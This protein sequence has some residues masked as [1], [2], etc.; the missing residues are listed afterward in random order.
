MST[1]EGISRRTLFK[2][3]GGGIVIFIGLEPLIVRAQDARRLYPEDFNAYLIVGDNGRVTVFSGKI[4]MGQGVLTSQAQMVAE[5]LDVELAAIDMVLGDTD[6]CPWDMGT[7]GSLT[8]RMFGP[9]LRAAA[10]KARLALM[11]L[12]AQKLGVPAK[13]LFVKDGVVS[14]IAEPS[15]RLS[16]G[17]LSKGARIAQVVDQNA[18]LRS[19]SK[20]RVMGS[21]PMRLDAL[22][23]V[24][25]AAKYAADIRIPGMVYAR[26]LRPPMHGAQLLKLD[27]SDA[28]KLAG[29]TLIKRGDLIA[30]L[31]M[32]PEA[33]GA[34]LAKIKADWRL[35]E[36]TVDQDSIFE[37]I[38]KHAVDQ[39]TIANKGDLVAAR[40]AATRLFE[41]TYQKGYVAHAAI[42][43]HAA[44]AEIKG[45]KATIWAS[46]QTPF[47]TRDRIAKILGLEQKN[48]RVLTPFLGGGFGGKS[49]DDQAVEAAQLAQ[50]C[51][52]PVQ[53][54]WSRAEEFFYDR[55][56]PAAV[57][58][59]VSGTNQGGRIALWDYSVF[60]AGE[61]GATSFYDIPNTRIR[62][63]GGT[64]YGSESAR[65]S[66]HPFA[67]G[68][69][70]APGAN[71]NIFASESQIDLMASAAG[72]DPL[73]FRLRNLTDLRMHRVLTAVAEA[74][75]WKA[76]AAPSGRGFG[77]ACSVDAGTY[78]AT[79]AEVKVNSV[80]GQIKV[81]R[82]VCAQDMGIVVNPEGAKMQIEG[83]ITMGLGYTLTEELQFHGGE[84]LDHNF[85]S[86]AI[87]RFSW[88]PQI[89][90]VLVKN[91][92]LAPQGG[93]EPA[94]TTTGAVIAN[95]VFDATGV[96]MTQLP[97][98][99][100]RIRQAIIAKNAKGKTAAVE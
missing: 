93:G 75:G 92:D 41:T 62:S 13:E 46:T 97:M 35:P 49:A 64:T 69:W 29:I 71:M 76:A 30:V 52:K 82:I 24:T 27:T 77:L 99:T 80:T 89:K 91:D 31:H 7:F 21:S 5:E 72:V 84:I 44:L 79:M 14:V 68:P 66:V 95:A 59:I 50:I 9:A 65:V 73:A 17:A 3:A 28:E 6:K 54:A 63:S 48:V 56:D 23:K 26:I 90:A 15:R 2:L 18:A 96:R 32:D 81:V 87:P 16:Y 74:F 33:A 36:Q 12:A 83:G 38:V 94:I 55:F 4:E 40:A 37:F 88:S 42:E 19:V 53:V 34:A 100:K 61:R 51:G 98:T 25:G 22:E 86:Y 85:D 47:P 20:F 1:P 11:T 10:A 43:P 67:V 58:K 70:R 45:G 78:V 8:T 60:A 39:K 57:V